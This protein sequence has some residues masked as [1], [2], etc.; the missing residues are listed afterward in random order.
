MIDVISLQKR[1]GN[2]SALTNVSLSVA[3]GQVVGFVGPNGSGKS[4]TLRIIS[5]L[6][7]CD[8]GRCTVD[9]IDAANLSHPWSKLATVLDR[10]G[11]NGELTALQAMQALGSAYGVPSE[12]IT[13]LIEMV[14]LGYAKRRRVRSYSLGMKQRLSLALALL[15]EPD[16]LVLDEPMNGLDPDGILWLRNF[17]LNYRSQGGGVLLSSHTLSEVEIISDVFVIIKDGITVWKGP[18]EQLL[19]SATTHVKAQDQSS[20]LKALDRLGYEFEVHA[21]GVYVQKEFPASLGPKL[22]SE[23]VPITCLKEVDRSLE[24]IYLSFSKENERE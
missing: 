3:R 18:K 14:G 20:L 24:D 6:E 21:D 5:G 8:S 11:V 22:V 23:G 19:D 16:Y 2:I 1:Y 4:T 12:R 17:L 9:G 10:Q 13:S 15:A 7:R